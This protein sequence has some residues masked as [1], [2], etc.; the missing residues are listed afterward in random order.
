MEQVNVSGVALVVVVKIVI[1]QHV[2]CAKVQEDVM[3]QHHQVI[4]VVEQVKL[5]KH[6]V[7]T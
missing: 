6:N 3:S 5:P 2:K 1:K 7:K 4:D